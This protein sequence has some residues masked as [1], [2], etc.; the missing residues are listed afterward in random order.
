MKTEVKSPPPPLLHTWNKREPKEKTK[1]V[2]MRKRA[3]LMEEVCNCWERAE[4]RFLD[5]NQIKK[6]AS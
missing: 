5:G 4:K 1:K 6:T 2:V 3:V